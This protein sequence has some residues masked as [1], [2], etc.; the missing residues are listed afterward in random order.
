MAE[1]ATL[2]SASAATGVK[3]DTPV[4][5]GVEWSREARQRTPFESLRVARDRLEQRYAAQV[6]KRRA[7]DQTTALPP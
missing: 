7:E 2:V 4:L 5:V 3:L 1:H 6:E